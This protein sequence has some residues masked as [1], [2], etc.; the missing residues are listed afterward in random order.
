MVFILGHLFRMVCPLLYRELV[1][2]CRDGVGIMPTPGVVCIRGNLIEAL[3]TRVRRRFRLRSSPEDGGM[4]PTRGVVCV[5]SDVAKGNF[6]R[7]STEDFWML[8]VLIWE[9]RGRAP[10]AFSGGG[11]WSSRVA[12][13]PSVQ[14][15]AASTCPGEIARSN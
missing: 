2:A 1:N 14:C 13:C 8:A 5:L 7:S 11:P 15:S 12:G 6:V 4:L 3:L 10:R 9:S